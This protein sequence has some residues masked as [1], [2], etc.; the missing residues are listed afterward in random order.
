MSDTPIPDGYYVIGGF[1]RTKF[2]AV[3]KDR[4]TVLG[5]PLS[6]PAHSIWIVES[7]PNHVGNTGFVR[8]TN[9]QSG[10]RVAARPG[11]RRGPPIPPP[12][13][14]GVVHQLA[15]NADSKDYDLWRLKFAG[16][17]NDKFALVNHNSQGTEMVMNLKPGPDGEVPELSDVIMWEWSGGQENEVWAFTKVDEARLPPR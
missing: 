2:L 16:G 13:R 9:Y 6:L 12:E 17:D 8:L 10:L 11:P 7:M 4:F 5:A 3:Y 1:T 15:P 14:G